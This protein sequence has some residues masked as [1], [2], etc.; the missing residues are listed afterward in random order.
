[1]N[2]KHGIL[3]VMFGLLVFCTFIGTASAA[4][5]YV[6]DD[7]AKIQWAID[8]ATAGN[9]IIVRDGTY[10]ENVDVNKCLTIRSDNGSEVTIVV[11]SFHGH[12]PVFRITA[13]QVNISG[14]TVKGLDEFTF[15]TGIQIRN[16][17]YCNISNNIL[18]SNERGISL[19]SSS[20]NTVVD[21]I[22]NSNEMEGIMLHNASNS[23]IIDNTINSNGDGIYLPGS[24][25]NTIEN[26][27]ISL[28]RRAGIYH[29]GSSNTKISNNTFEKDGIWLQGGELSHF[30]THI[31]E[32]NM[33]NKKPVY[34]YKNTSSIKVPEDAGEVIF[35]NCSDMT[36]ENINASS[37]TVGL[38]IA[39]TC[40]SLISNNNADSNNMSGI[41]I[42]SSSDNTIENNNVSNNVAGICFE[43]S[44][45]NKVWNNNVSMQNGAGIHFLWSYDN[46]I[47]LNNFIDNGV[48]VYSPNF[49]NIW[50]STEEITYIY[51]GETY[52]NY[53]GNYWSDYTGSDVV[54][55]GVGD[56]P[57]EIWGGGEDIYP[58]ME[59]WENFVV[60]TGVKG[61]L[62]GDGKV[63]ATDAVIALQIAVGSSSYDEAA[64]M[65]G[66]GRITSLDALMI[67]QAAAGGITL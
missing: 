47:Y 31:I 61:D 40:G 10:S 56:T 34:Y 4:T 42:V 44:S 12:E 65:S 30:N 1:M 13:N 54:G 62:N 19:E 38:V 22:A 50:N 39:Y 25:H 15:G 51:K 48:N 60:V 8:N 33:V 49:A 35:A 23:I 26:N 59:R 21:N 2:T 5:I 53:L 6:P 64:D 17:N 58:L 18:I 57:Y 45:N 20:H 37:G 52:E 66:D 32:N 27:T 43:H 16:A 14:F 7:H 46:I 11:N 55:D 67:L 28:N 9:T 63:T 29:W 3:L 24:S 36:V 41:C